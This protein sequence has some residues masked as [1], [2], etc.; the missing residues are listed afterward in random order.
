MAASTGDAVQRGEV[1][2]HN[3]RGGADRGEG[4]WIWVT[5]DEWWSQGLKGQGEEGLA[6]GME[7]PCGCRCLRKM[8][9]AE[10]RGDRCS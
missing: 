9:R 10:G 5:Q 8:A 6:L 4:P 1:G 7:C 2:A 3:F